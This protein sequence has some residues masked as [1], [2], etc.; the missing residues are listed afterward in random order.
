MRR[1]GLTG[2]FWPTREQEFLLR[3]AL[4]EQE[5]ALEAWQEVR[6]RL[7]IER[8]EEGSFAL[9]PLI[10]RRLTEADVEDVS[11][12]K[13]R[14]IYRHT[15]SRNQL[16]LEELKVLLRVLRDGGLEAAPLRGA[17]VLLGYYP[18]RGLRPVNELEL[19]VPEGDAKKALRGLTAAGWTPRRPTAEDWPAVRL[20]SSGR[21][22]VVHWRL[23]PEFDPEGRWNGDFWSATR[24]FELDEVSTRMLAPADEFLHSTLTGARSAPFT[25]F[26]WIA[27]ARMIL[28]AEPQF[29]W[30]RVVEQAAKRRAWLTLRDALTYL[31][32][33]LDTPIPAHVF[34]ELDAAGPTRRDVVAHKT[35]AWGG[36]VAGE[37]PRAL[38]QYLR[39]TAGDGA[40][41]TVAGAPAFLRD[42]WKLDHTCQVPLLAAKKGFS[43]LAARGR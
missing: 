36:K 38:A 23:L 19:F 22:L 26:Q 1:R 25:T 34:D 15:W 43:R 33:S 9:L 11:L 6:P 4:L 24:Q 28:Q 39:S 7:D 27:D 14:G 13:L 20:F 29:D 32:N 31:S 18:E 30:D 8:L 10:F 2:D 3:A 16:A 21:T 37:L 35:G 40:L 42:T 17:A 12:G 5:P 41:R